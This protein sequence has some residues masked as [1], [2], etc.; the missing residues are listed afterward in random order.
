MTQGSI[1]LVVYNY[2]Q[3]H[4]RRRENNLVHAHKDI[5]LA[6]YYYYKWECID[7]NTSNFVSAVGLK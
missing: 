5:I 4:S 3:I 6:S 1:K 2:S 7:L